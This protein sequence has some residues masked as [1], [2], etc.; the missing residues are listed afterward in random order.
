MAMSRLQMALQKSMT[1]FPQ[2][3]VSFCSTTTYPP[4]TRPLQRSHLNPITSTRRQSRRANVQKRDWAHEVDI[5]KPMINF[6]ELVPEMAHK[7]CARLSSNDMT[8]EQDDL[9]SARSS[10][11]RSRRRLCIISRWGTRS[12]LRLTH[13]QERLLSRSTPL[14]SRQST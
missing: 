2:V 4:L 12:L 7:V 11:T 10:W 3:S 5:N 6:H 8:A 9:H 13:Q 14:R 1:F